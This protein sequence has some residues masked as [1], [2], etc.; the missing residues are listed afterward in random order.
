MKKRVGYISNEQKNTLMELMDK[1]PNL[2]NGRFSATFTKKDGQN[3]WHEI[4]SILNA[5]PGAKKDWI[6]WRKED[7]LTKTLEDV[8][9][10]AISKETVLNSKIKV[11]ETFALK[12]FNN[13]PQEKSGSL[14]AKHAS[15]YIILIIYYVV[16]FQRHPTCTLSVSKA[17][18]SSRISPA[19]SRLLT[20]V[21]IHSFKE[22]T[23]HYQQRT[24]L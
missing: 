15:E 8:K 12:S 9:K 5:I 10:L 13:R 18:N 17:K 22:C 6:H 14:K 7:C 19:Q 4:A 2:I 16:R 21:C 20:T 11:E 23:V 24:G 3:Q 1:Y